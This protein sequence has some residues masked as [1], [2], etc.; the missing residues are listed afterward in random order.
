MEKKIQ[1]T[2]GDPKPEPKTP[3]T[4]TGPAQPSSGAP[5]SDKK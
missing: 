2:I 4:G 3:D 5:S 1:T